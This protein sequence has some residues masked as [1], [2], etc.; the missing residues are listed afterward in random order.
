MY[1]I[2]RILSAFGLLMILTAAC[3]GSGEMVSPN[4]K[5][6]VSQMEQSDGSST[7]SVCYDDGAVRTEVL[8]IP[9]VG[10]ITQAGRGGDMRLTGI[11]APT[12]IVDKYTMLTGKQLECSNEANEYLI[13]FEDSIGK[14]VLMR[15]RLYDDGVA[16]R[17]ELPDLTNDYIIDELT[18]Y[19]IAEGTRR[20]MQA[21]VVGYEDFYPMYVNGHATEKRQWGYPALVQSGDS[22]WALISE[23]DVNR[24]QG[25]SFM[26]NTVAP[27]DYKVQM[28]QNQQ[29]INSDWHTPWRVL[30]VGT[31]NDVVESTLITD[32]SSPA[33]VTTDLDWI[34]PG[35]VSWIYW[36]NNHGSK[37]YELIKRY[38]DMAVELNLPYVLIDWE[39]DVMGNGGTIE[40]A[41]RYAN[42]NNVR[43][44]M[45]YNSSTSWVDGAAGPL[46]RLNKPADREREFAWLKSIGVAGVKID[47]FPD[48]SEPTMAYYQDLLETAA[49]YGL[50]V[51]FH[52]AAIPRGWQRT[53]PNLMSVEAVYGAEW[54]NNLPVLTD[55]AAAHNATL[56]FTRNVIGPMDYTP[57]TFSDSQHPHI[58]THAHELALPVVFESALQHWADSPESYLAQPA[59]VK[60]FI[61]YLPTVWDETR[62]VGGYPADYVVMARRRG[63]VWYVGA[64]NGTDRTRTLPMDWGFLSPDSTYCVTLF[65]DSGNKENPWKTST[66]QGSVGNLPASL[67]CEPRGGFVAVIRPAK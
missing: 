4:S 33:V 32:T 1:K 10:I 15:M 40:D 53:Y 5:L 18:T 3:S 6:V 31:L 47:F 48:D 27:T 39:W 9:A 61:G 23:S 22:V 28:M 36:A 50:M 12:H 34:K 26:V 30:I 52:G 38:V 41:V 63:D 43:P 24:L 25:G 49:K 51:N 13:H 65:E 17:Y 19:R 66:N 46:F 60:E 58:T 59:E 35:G 64:L 54:Y 57:C 7:F 62:L 16:F 44:L 20:W 37:D 11:D 45:W 8:T 21:Y 67:A 56:P 42:E 14:K 29:I 2:I 55:K